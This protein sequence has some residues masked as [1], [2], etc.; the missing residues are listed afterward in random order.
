MDDSGRGVTPLAEV[1]RQRRL[2]LGLSQYEL[3]R[4]AGVTRSA[5]NALEHGGI[6]EPRAGVFSRLAAALELTGDDLLTRIGKGAPRTVGGSVDWR[7][8]IR[9]HPALSDTAKRA[10]IELIESYKG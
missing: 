7:D 3:A 6:K 9:G 4:R 8:A 1:V 10:L 5:V 2:E